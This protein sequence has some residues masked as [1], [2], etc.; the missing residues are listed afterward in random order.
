MVE[1]YMRVNA[2]AEH[3]PAN[4]RSISGSTKFPVAVFTGS[5]AYPVVTWP[6]ATEAG[7]TAIGAREASTPAA[8]SAASTDAFEI[9]A[10]DPS[11]P[12]ASNAAA[13]V[14]AHDTS[15]P[16]FA[17]YVSKADSTPLASTD[18]HPQ[19]ALNAS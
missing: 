14:F 13:T 12:A 3:P 16:L 19:P 5:S 1:L 17:M 9:V 18:P 8:A 10:T 15:L 7:F 6:P 2:K 11:E 4:A